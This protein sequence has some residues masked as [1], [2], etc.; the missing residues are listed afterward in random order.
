MKN[1]IRFSLVVFL[2]ITTI[3][4]CKDKDEPITDNQ[5]TSFNWRLD[6]IGQIGGA[7]AVTQEYFDSAGFF[8]SAELVFTF[9]T[10]FSITAYYN[11]L[12]GNGNYELKIDNKILVDNFHRVDR[13]GAS[14]IWYNSA[15][16]AINDAESYSIVENK[17]S[18]F[19]QSNTRQMHFT[20]L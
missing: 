19:F 4:G 7:G 9:N 3:I 15:E 6:S 1:I 8:Q 17:L 11:G 13:M 14:S 18:I 12:Q 10:D 20:K 16:S 5:L 2:G